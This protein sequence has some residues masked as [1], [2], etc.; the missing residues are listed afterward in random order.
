MIEKLRYINHMNEV[1]EF[2]SNGLFV[3]ESDLYD[4]AWNITKKNDKI[5]ALTTGIVKKS[6]PVVIMCNTEK[7]GIAKRNDILEI[8]EK[9]VLAMKHGRFVIG[10]YYLKCY[11]TGN[12]YKSY[13][14]S[15]RYALLT[16]TIQTDCP[17]WIKETTTTFGYGGGR[18]GKN[19]DYNNDFPYDYASNLLSQEL[20]NA[21]FIPSNFRMNIYGACQN[22][23]VTIGGHVYEIAVSVE[24]NE[25][26]RVDSVNKSITLIH[27]DGTQTNCF[28]LRNRDSYIFEKIPVGRSAV[29]NNSDFKFD[30]TLLEERSAPKWT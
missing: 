25:Y 6:I 7:E 8:C 29:S 9:D 26:L 14:D 2:G 21:D 28:N 4:F 30:I 13:T 15:K 24:A 1:I 17:K 20:V 22:P 19:L 5:S 3:N 11:V 12:K 23:Q 16:L 27:T 18:A 10:D